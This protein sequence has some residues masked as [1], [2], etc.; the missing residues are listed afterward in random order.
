MLDCRKY[1][2]SF[3]GDQVSAFLLAW[4][5]FRVLS[6]SFEFLLLRY[7]NV[8]GISGLD[9]VICV[10][11]GLWQATANTVFCLYYG[12]KEGARSEIFKE[13]LVHLIRI[14]ETGEKLEVCTVENLGP[15]VSKNKVI[16]VKSNGSSVR[17]WRDCQESR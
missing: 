1:A 5:M 12:S 10:F 16:K 3:S 15:G 13:A 6:W 7:A 8:S 14:T 9:P 17:G 4:F 11:M 2:C